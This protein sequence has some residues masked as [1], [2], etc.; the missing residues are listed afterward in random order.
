MKF[1]EY[2]KAQKNIKKCKQLLKLTNELCKAYNESPTKCAK[3]PAYLYSDAEALYFC[4]QGRVMKQANKVWLGV[5]A[6]P[7]EEA[8]SCSDDVPYYLKEE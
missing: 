1:T 7:D 3:C 4:A 2:I 8:E 5:D 6:D